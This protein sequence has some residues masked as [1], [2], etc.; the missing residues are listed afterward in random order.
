MYFDTGSK[1]S[2][3]N[4]TESKYSLSPGNE[5]SFYTTEFLET[6]RFL[7][8]KDP[9]PC[10]TMIDNKKLSTVAPARDKKTKR[11]AQRKRQ[12]KVGGFT[13]SMQQAKVDMRKVARSTVG[14]PVVCAFILLQTRILRGLALSR[15][16]KSSPAY[17]PQ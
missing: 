1:P 9:L 11:H 2:C 7:K 14:Q 5:T 8:R 4:P 13:N 6:T 10:F 12:K 15:P 16:A 17:H 3:A